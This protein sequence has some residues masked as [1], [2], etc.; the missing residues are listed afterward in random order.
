MKLFFVS[1]LVVV[2]FANIPYIVEQA[3]N[4]QDIALDIFSRLMQDRIIMINGK[5]DGNTSAV[6][7]A[8]LL[9]LEAENSEKPISLYITSPGGSVTAGMAMYDTMQFI[10]A[11]VATYCNG[12]CYSMAA[13]LLCAGAKGQRYA[14]PNARIMI[15]QPSDTISGKALDVEIYNKELILW[16]ERLS[17]IISK[18]SGNDNATIAKAMD[19][20]F[21][22]DAS[23]ALSFGIIDKIKTQHNEL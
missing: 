21:F 20:D 22:M 6:V 7:V 13:V 5:I 10:K 19:R 14:F 18:H 1:A 9:H 23:Q 16:N 4:G 11:P 2:C 12:E 8:Q 15:H 17:A 3:P